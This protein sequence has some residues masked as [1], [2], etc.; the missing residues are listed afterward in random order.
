MPN[1]YRYLL[2][3]GF[4]DKKRKGMKNVLSKKNQNLRIPKSG[5]I[6]IKQFKISTKF[7]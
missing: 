6:K 5:C 4:V 1:M 2:G 3:E 7:Q